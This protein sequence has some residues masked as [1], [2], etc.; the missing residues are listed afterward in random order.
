MCYLPLCSFLV[1]ELAPGSNGLTLG[2][3]GSCWSPSLLFGKEVMDLVPFS[4]AAAMAAVQ[5]F[6]GY[7]QHSGIVK[8]R[9][10]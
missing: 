9:D 1:P 7:W 5:V 8:S 2:N 3:S 10:I 4:E 6:L